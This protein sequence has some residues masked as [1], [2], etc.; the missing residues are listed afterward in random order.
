MATPIMDVSML[1]HFSPIFIFILIFAF[2]YGAMIKTKVLGDNK[3]IIGI[4]S[5]VVSLIFILI[6][7]LT[8][9][10]LIIAPWFTALF[11]FLIFSIVVFKL[12]GAS[13]DDI[14]TVIKNHS[15]LHWT[16]IIICIIIAVGAIA[17]VFGQQSL[18]TGYGSGASSSTVSIDETG[19]VIV[20]GGPGQQYQGQTTAGTSFSN[21]LAATLYHPKT[22][23]LIF[24]LIIA[25]LSGAMLTG[26][27]TPSWPQ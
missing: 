11:I 7:P 14:S 23:G 2:L 3:I 1:A 15:T 4:I 18:E 17:A 21:N 25:A 27:M 24:I 26:K 6:A 13:D 22:L 12:F 20:V 19:D 5:L 10:V 9:I 16:L 8:K